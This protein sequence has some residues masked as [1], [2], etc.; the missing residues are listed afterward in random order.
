MANNMPRPRRLTAG[1]VVVGL[2]LLTVVVHVWF[3]SGMRRSQAGTSAVHSKPAGAEDKESYKDIFQRRGQLYNK[4]ML[5]SPE[6]RLQE[7]MPL[8]NE[9]DLQPGDVLIDAP[10]GGDYVAEGVFK[11]LPQATSSALK[12]FSVEP[13]SV[14]SQS[15]STNGGHG[16]VSSFLQDAARVKH[17]TAQLVDIPLPPSSATKLSSLAGLH[18]L[19]LSEKM[20]FFDESSRLLTPGGK[21]VVAD[22][23]VGTGPSYFLNDCADRLTVTGHKGMFFR[24]NELSAFLLRSGFE[25]IKEEY[26]ELDWAFK[27]ELELLQ[28]VRDLFGLENTFLNERSPDEAIV[29][30]RVRKEV[31]RYLNYKVFDKGLATERAL[32]PWGLRYATGS[33]PRLDFVP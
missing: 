18:H 15:G 7:L 19:S 1:K 5:R 2:L 11:Y 13:S 31:L 14:F 27:S 9:L 3:F 25:D 33:K 16:S 6:A 24:E 8:L 21:M 10:A 17:V 22:V 28:F 4:A 12:I 29:M 23:G 32:L 26:V 30:T 20:A